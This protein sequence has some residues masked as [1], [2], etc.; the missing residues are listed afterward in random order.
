MP[1]NK[2]AM[3]AGDANGSGGIAANDINSYWRPQN[4]FSGYLPGDFNLSG[5]VAANDLN[6]FW[7]SNNGKSSLT[8]Q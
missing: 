4:G 8:P 5:G 7:R 1:D 6:E 3:I 2:L